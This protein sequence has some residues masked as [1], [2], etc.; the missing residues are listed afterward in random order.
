MRD[1]VADFLDLLNEER[2]LL[3]EGRSDGLADLAAR[4]ESLAATLEASRPTR[5]D[6]VR[7]AQAMSRS[8]SLLT[9]CRNGLRD[10]H[11]RLEQVR[12]VRAGLNHYTRNGTV[13]TIAA[14]GPALE[15]RA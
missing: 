11:A 6:L 15:K 1:P 12:S 4:K 8:E 5:G 14:T 7:I 9:A 13:E 2:A 3:L 10:A